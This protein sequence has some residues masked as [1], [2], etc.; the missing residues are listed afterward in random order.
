MS[1]R[2]LFFKILKRKRSALP[3]SVTHAMTLKITTA[4]M[5]NSQVIHVPLHQ[6]NTN[7]QFVENEKEENM[8]L[9]QSNNN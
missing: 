8:S 9:E 7:P 4:N 1:V 6:H 2:G 5:D 3:A